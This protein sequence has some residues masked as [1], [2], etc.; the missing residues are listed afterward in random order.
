VEQ[1]TDAP[2]SQNEL[3]MVLRPVMSR[4]AMNHEALVA[5]S[6]RIDV[7]QQATTDPLVLAPIALEL[8]DLEAVLKWSAFDPI[9]QSIN[10]Q[11][12]AQ[13]NALGRLIGSVDGPRE[14]A[15]ARRSSLPI[16][17]SRASSLRTP[18]R[19]CATPQFSTPSRSIR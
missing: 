13:R 3:A 14:S 2:V 6:A 15:G 12:D 18:A 4:L 10:A 17:R 5:L 8:D 16:S 9:L 1:L 7:L 19:R 11:L